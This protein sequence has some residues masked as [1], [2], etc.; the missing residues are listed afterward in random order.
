MV[1]WEGLFCGVCL[2]TCPQGQMKEQIK[3]LKNADEAL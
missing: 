1:N 2:T 3:K